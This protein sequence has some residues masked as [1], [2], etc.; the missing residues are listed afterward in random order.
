[1]PPKGAASPFACR[2]AADSGADASKDGQNTSAM[3]AMITIISTP[4]A[5]VA[6]QAIPGR[7]LSALAPI[8][9]PSVSE[10]MRR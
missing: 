7:M 9:R 6:F 10:R 4:A 3:T 2:L 1:M 8:G 5:R